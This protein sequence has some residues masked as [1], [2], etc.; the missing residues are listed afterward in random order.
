MN[1]MDLSALHAGFPGIT[2]AWGESLA[3]AASVSLESQ[4]HSAPTDCAVDGSISALLA[5]SWPTTSEQMRRTWND[6]DEAV[7][8]GA[9]GMAALL[10]AAHTDL[11]VV[12]RS[13]KGTGFDYWLGPKGDDSALFQKTAR[14]EVSG[15]GRGNESAVRARVKTKMEQTTV[16]DGVL[17]AY[18]VVVEFG[19]PR[20][21]VIQK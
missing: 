14:L 2:P 16:S 13:R 11:E 10:V 8:H 1:A 4:G 18:V 9:Y 7:E 3:Q 5:L 12:E 20:A 21:R 6:L 19:S 15:I 17:P